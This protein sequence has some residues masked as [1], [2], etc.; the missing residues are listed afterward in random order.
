MRGTTRLERVL[1]FLISVLRYCHGISDD[2]PDIILCIEV[3]TSIYASFVL[4][5]WVVNKRLDEVGQSLL[6]LTP[7]ALQSVVRV[8]ALV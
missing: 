4:S 1:Y 7:L 5:C 8:P 3:L 6:V 2:S